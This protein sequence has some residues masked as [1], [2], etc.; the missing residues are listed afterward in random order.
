VDTV[1]LP[2]L[3]AIEVAPVPITEE[4]VWLNFVLNS[5]G[6]LGMLQ[7]LNASTLIGAAEK[8]PLFEA[9]GNLTGIVGWKRRSWRPPSLFLDNRRATV[10]AASANTNG[11]PLPEHSGP[12]R[13]PVWLYEKHPKI[14]ALE[15]VLDGPPLRYP[16][17]LYVPTPAQQSSLAVFGQLMLPFHVLN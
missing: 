5:H 10:R 13:S 8:E 17:A 1:R 2:R 3:E 7:L 11:L 15:L 12:R 6:G 9:L 4:L 14:L 16:K